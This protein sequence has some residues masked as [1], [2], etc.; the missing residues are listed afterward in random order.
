MVLD[1]TGM[2]RQVAS[3]REGHA[4]KG[5][6]RSQEHAGRV[7]LQHTVDSRDSILDVE[8]HEVSVE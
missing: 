3:A 5:E 7:R 4:R 8:T 1:C 6:A 2:P